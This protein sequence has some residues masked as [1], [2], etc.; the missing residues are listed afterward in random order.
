MTSS[1]ATETHADNAQQ[2]TN[3]AAPRLRVVEVTEVVG[4]IVHSLV[5]NVVEFLDDTVSVDAESVKLLSS[6]KM[7]SSPKMLSSPNM[8]HLS[9]DEAFELLEAHQGDD[10]VLLPEHDDGA[11][12]D[13]EA[14]PTKNRE[15]Q[16][17]DGDDDDDEGSQLKRPP[18]WTYQK[19]P[20]T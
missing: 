6:P 2:R 1:D 4:Q 11:D 15:Y 10:H 12:A 17:F 13:V 16:W 20:T 8:P 3:D 14:E 7:H 19:P 5:D 9:A 18:C